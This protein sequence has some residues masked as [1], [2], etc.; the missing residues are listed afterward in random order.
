MEIIGIQTDIAWEDRDTNFARV[1]AMLAT[2]RV[3]PESLIVLPEL[4]ATGFT[5]DVTRTADT[6]ARETEVFLSDLAKRLR[7]NVLGGVARRTNGKAANEA[8][9][10]DPDGRTVM[11]Y[12]KIHPFSLAGE[13]QHYQA[14]DL[15]A[16]FECGGFTLAPFI[17]YDLRFPEVFRAAAELGADFFVVIANWPAPRIYHWTTL[18]KARAVENLA[19][20]V[21]INRAGAD[22]SHSY[23]GKSMIVS[24][25]GETL[26]EADGGPCIL[27]A[28]CSPRTVADWR[29]A[30]PALRDRRRQFCFLNP[31]DPDHP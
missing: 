20:V 7:C 30:F 2:I 14:G 4:F 19:Y 31:D 28:T 29:L 16:T 11:R 18:L 5:M 3:A 12:R 25:Q 24:P 13:G 10:C 26:A 17:C 21:G 22:P 1:N 8:V 9:M 23:P 27:R 15:V 6:A